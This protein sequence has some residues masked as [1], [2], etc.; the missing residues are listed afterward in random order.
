MKKNPIKRRKYFI[1]KFKLISPLLRRDE[2]L[3]QKILKD[4]FYLHQ[5]NSK[6]CM[7]IILLFI[8]AAQVL[9][10]CAQESQNWDKEILEVK[11]D[12]STNFVINAD[13]IFIDRW[14][15]LPQPQFWKVIMRMSPDSILINSAKNRDILLKIAVND[16]N[17]LSESKK[18]TIKD[19]LR[20]AFGL[21]PDATLNCTTGKN[22]FY[23]FD[24]VYPSISKGV[25]AFHKNGVDPWYAQSILLIESPGQ[26]KKSNVGAYGAFQLMPSVARKYGLI[27]NDVK[28]EREDFQKSAIAAASLIKKSCIPSAKRLLNLYN[29]TY[30][31]TDIWFRLF[32]LHVYHA[33]AGNIEAVLSK[34]K[35]TSG[36]QTLITTMW[37]T[38]AGQFGNS[39]QNYSQLALAAQLI[40]HEMVY[41]NC[42]SLENYSGK[43]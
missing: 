17:K 34:I 42:D 4:Y 19:S 27:V 31:E 30:N 36:G 15:Q 23:N 32:V 28:D 37:Q 21:K 1:I 43:M 39:S 2:S 13:G 18:A 38:T 12:D 22:H 3:K 26:L 24:A 14:D 41:K 8:I 7:R 9:V 25:E 29:L 5:S 11:Q 40:L 10:S 6:N 20:N 16:W 35:P 33:G